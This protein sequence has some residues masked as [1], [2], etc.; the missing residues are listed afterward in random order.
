[1][2]AL[3]LISTG[4]RNLTEL[5]CNKTHNAVYKCVSASVQL[6]KSIQHPDMTKMC[7]AVTADTDPAQYA[8]MPAWVFLKHFLQQTP[9]TRLFCTHHSPYLIYLSV[10]AWTHKHALSGLIMSCTLVYTYLK[11]CSCLVQ[12]WETVKELIIFLAAISK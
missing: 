9:D 8:V 11:S 10:W 4:T 2:Y 5:L 7:S 12:N 1:M 6:S 3:Y